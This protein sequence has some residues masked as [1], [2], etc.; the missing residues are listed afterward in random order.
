VLQP[1]TSGAALIQ[2]IDQTITATPT[3]WWLGQSGF[4]VRF[5][6]ITFYID[7]CFSTPA[8]KRRLIAAPLSGAEVPTPT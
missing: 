7:P 4:I 8:S 3:L 2:E 1:R 6:N 5:A